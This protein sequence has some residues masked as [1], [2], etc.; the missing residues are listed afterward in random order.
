MDDQRS[1]AEQGDDI[2]GIVDDDSGGKACWGAICLEERHS[3]GRRVGIHRA[4]AAGES[5]APRA[6]NDV[7]SFAG[8]AWAEIITKKN[9]RSNRQST[10]LKNYVRATW[11]RLTGVNR[12][13]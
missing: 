4:V 13:G 7:S 1:V 3:T 12:Y 9:N 6:S 2:L 10:V 11:I 5:H 8:A